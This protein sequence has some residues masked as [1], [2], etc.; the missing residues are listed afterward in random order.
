ML[1]RL[2]DRTADKGLLIFYTEFFFK[3]TNLCVRDIDLL[4]LIYYIIILLIYK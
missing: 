3:N 2:N 1:Y 4:E